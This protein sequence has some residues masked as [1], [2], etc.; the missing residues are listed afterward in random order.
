MQRNSRLSLSVRPLLIAT[1]ALLSG[2]ALAQDDEPGINDLLDSIPE[3]EAAKSA[4]MLAQEA[5]ANKPP[6]VSF[7]DY[8]NAVRD[9]VLAHWTPKA[10]VIKKN[11]RAAAQVLVKVGDT[12]AII[13]IALIEASG[14]KKFD[15]SMLAAL[16]AID[17]VTVPPPSFAGDAERGIIVSFVAANAPR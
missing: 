15:K 9:D 16:N 12:G 1:A 4:E 7:P 11:P 10:S 13:D 5:E 3:I 8:M 2:A 14:D 17:T 6:D